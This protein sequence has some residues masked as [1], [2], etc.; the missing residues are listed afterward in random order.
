MANLPRLSGMNAYLRPAAIPKHFPDPVSFIRLLRRLF[1][2]RPAEPA[3]EP[4]PEKPP[5]RRQPETEPEPRPSEPPARLSPPQPARILY[6]EGSA[7]LRDPLAQLLELGSDYEIAVASN[8]REGVQKVNTWQPDLILTGL[9]MPIMDGYEAIQ[10][11][12]SNPET[13]EIPI[14]VISAWAD[15]TSKARAL[16]AGANEHLT[17]PIDIDRL[18]G[19]IDRYLNDG[20]S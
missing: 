3:P 7:S 10:T 13:A 12:R 11:I 18:L 9:R 20:H 19:K 6:I 17:P 4:L 1:R 15:A 16:A 5:G 2:P 8:G 14:I